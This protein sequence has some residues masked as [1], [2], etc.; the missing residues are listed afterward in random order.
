MR[1]FPILGLT[2]SLHVFPS[3]WSHLSCAS[4]ASISP[5][6]LD[7]K[8]ISHQRVPPH[9]AYVRHIYHQNPR[10]YF[11]L[12]PC[13]SFTLLVS[14]IVSI[15]RFLSSHLSRV[16]VAPFVRAV[17]CVVKLKP[18]SRPSVHVVIHS[19]TIVHTPCNPHQARE[20]R[21]SLLQ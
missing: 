18:H 12:L 16:S 8:D 19:A 3:H 7:G 6:S 9:V 13:I 21:S 15:I 10:P 1:C 4:T 17:R 2:P 11:T 14:R 20:H 5:P